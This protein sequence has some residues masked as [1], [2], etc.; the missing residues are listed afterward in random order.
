MRDKRTA[1]HRRSRISLTLDPATI[2]RQKICSGR[3]IMR[4]VRGALIG[5]MAAGFSPLPR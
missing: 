4:I 1:L 2:V 5:F 3:T